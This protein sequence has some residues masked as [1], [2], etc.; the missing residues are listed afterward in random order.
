MKKL[1]TA[2]RKNDVH[3]AE[4]MLAKSPSVIDEVSHGA[5]K[6][7]EGQS[8]LQVAPKCA[9]YE[10]VHLLLAHGADVNFMEAESGANTWRTPVLHDAI[11]RAVKCS[12]WNSIGINGFEL[13][14]TEREADEAFEI[15][16]KMIALGANVN[17]KDNYGNACINRA[18]LQARQILPR[19]AVVCDRVLTPELRADIKRIFDLLIESGA[20]MNYIS[21][22][23][24]GKTYKE[25]YGG[26]PVGEF[27]KVR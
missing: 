26:E 8:P 19:D 25:E 18:C 11:N 17:G 23:S 6:K 21:P 13:M 14:S 3:T 2:I 16:K 20:D 22:N 24:F 12:R 1:F 10:I 15:L 4:T 9:S 27:L 5:P 7:D